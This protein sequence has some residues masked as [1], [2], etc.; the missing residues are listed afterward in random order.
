MSAKTK[1]V[2]QCIRDMLVGRTLRRA[3]VAECELAVIKVHVVGS[4]G[5]AVSY[6]M[7]LSRVREGDDCWL[8]ANHMEKM[9]VADEPEAA[10]M[11]DKALPMH[12][13][14][15]PNDPLRPSSCRHCGAVRHYTDTWEMMGECPARLRNALDAIVLSPEMAKSVLDEPEQDAASDVLDVALLLEKR[16]DALQEV[17]LRMQR[18]SQQVEWRVE[19]RKPDGERMVRYV[20]VPAD[21]NVFG[22]AIF[23]K[24]QGWTE[25][26][27]SASAAT[28]FAVGGAE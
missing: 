25:W 9:L 19:A 21:I 27:V 11:L 22:E 23:P 8:M 20:V 7:E 3:G 10:T 5:M 6:D 24:S 18:R 2:D 28:Q 15:V 14:P 4:N 16:L 26:D 13:E 17:V 12:H 1:M